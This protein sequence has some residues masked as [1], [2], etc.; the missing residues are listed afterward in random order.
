MKEIV[1][2][3]KIEDGKEAIRDPR[4]DEFYLNPDGSCLSAKFSFE[5]ESYPIYTRTEREVGSSG[6]T[7]EEAEKLIEEFIIDTDG[8]PEDVDWFE[9]QI[10]PFLNR[11]FPQPLPTPKCP[12]CQRYL[13]PCFEDNN[14]RCSLCGLTLEPRKGESEMEFYTRLNNPAPGAEKGKE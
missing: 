2:A 14:L 11:K 9:K 10:Q 5:E 8:V 6:M 12:Y 3:P 7:R 4:K 1:F 13:M